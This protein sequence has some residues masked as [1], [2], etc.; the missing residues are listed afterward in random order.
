VAGGERLRSYR[1]TGS[2]ARPRTGGCPATGPLGGGA[3]SRESAAERGDGYLAFEP[4]GPP[5]R[6]SNGHTVSE[7]EVP[8]ISPTDVEPVRLNEVSGVAIGRAQHGQ[9]EV[10][11]RNPAPA[12]FN[13]LR[14]ELAGPL[15]GAVELQQLLN[16]RLNKRR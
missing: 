2:V 3:R 10:A 1:T 16:R 4:R 8:I 5:R 6:G 9:D 15:G 14:D 7:G 13:S 11:G 12:E